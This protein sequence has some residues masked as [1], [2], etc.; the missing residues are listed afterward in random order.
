MKYEIFISDNPIKIICDNSKN[1]IEKVLMTSVRILL[2]HKLSYVKLYQI[3]QW[4][5][6]N[7][8]IEEYI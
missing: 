7:Y 3:M 6:D 4:N 2:K 8:M 5:Y 1:L